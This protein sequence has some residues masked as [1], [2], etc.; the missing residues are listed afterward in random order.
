MGIT[1]LQ[2]FLTEFEKDRML[3]LVLDVSD[4]LLIALSNILLE[5]L[6]GESGSNRCTNTCIGKEDDIAH[7]AVKMPLASHLGIG[8]LVETINADLYLTDIGRKVVDAFLGPK[9]AIGKYRR[10]KAYGES[11]CQD[12]IKVW[13]HQRFTTRE[14]NTLTAILLEFGKN[15][16]PFAL[17]QLVFQRISRMHET[18][19]ATEITCIG[20]IDVEHVIALKIICNWRGVDACKTSG[21]DSCQELLEQG[22]IVWCA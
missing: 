8:G 12:F 10:F 5:I 4:H 22:L 11:M 13:I 14:C 15:S 3:A 18:M 19:V 1:S 21:C 6:E 17:W 2:N 20:E 16:K 9:D 7:N